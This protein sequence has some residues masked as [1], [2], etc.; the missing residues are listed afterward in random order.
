MANK[1]VLVINSGSSSLKLGVYREDDLALAS[2]DVDALSDEPQWPASN[3]SDAPSAVGHRVVHGG[4]NLIKHQK[5]TPQLLSELERCVHFAPLHIPKSIELI[6]ESQRRY[7]DAQQFACFDTAF[8][9]TLPESAAHLPLPENLFA[10][11]VRKYGFHGLSYESIVAQLAANVPP[12]LVIAHL[13]SGASLAALKDGHSVDTTMGLTPTGGIPMATRSGDLDPGVLLYLM[14]V[15]GMTADSLE[16][17]LNSSS[18]QRALCGQSD[19]RKI[20]GAEDRHDPRARLAIDIFCLSIRKTIA[21][22]A[23]VLGGLDMIIFTGGIGENS[24]RVRSRVCDGLRFLGVSPEAHS[25]IPVRVLPS[26]EDL[27][28]ARHCRALTRSAT[29]VLT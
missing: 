27:Q 15:K 24:S 23:A 14:R 6:K 8:H 26:Q 20:E 19:M 28:I 5:I 4:P 12:H 9:Q 7:P 18:G 21:S 10:E 3:S 17:M 2:G 25:V 22:Y 1:T 13:G 29:T 16:E 11:G